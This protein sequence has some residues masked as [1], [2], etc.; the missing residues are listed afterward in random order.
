MMTRSYLDALSAGFS[1][2]LA[3]HF[4]YPPYTV[5]RI[6]GESDQPVSVQAGAA[7]KLLWD[8]L[9]VE[10]G[11]IYRVTVRADWTGVERDPSAG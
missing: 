1:L 11:Q 2:F 6:I 8:P 9:D 3:V 7:S 5:L 10:P 4:W